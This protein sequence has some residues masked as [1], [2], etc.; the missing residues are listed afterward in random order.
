MAIFTIISDF[1]MQYIPDFASNAAEYLL[2]GI[3]IAI[4]VGVIRR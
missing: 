2:L 3:L 4:I 1:L